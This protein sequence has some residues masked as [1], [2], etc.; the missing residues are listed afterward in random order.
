MTGVRR[1]IVV[2]TLT[3]AAS[4]AA[5]QEFRSGASS[6]RQADDRRAEPRQTDSTQRHNDVQRQTEAPRAVGPASTGAPA[7]GGTGPAVRAAASARAA[8]A[9]RH[10]GTLERSRARVAIAGARVAVGYRRP[11]GHAPSTRSGR[12]PRAAEDLHAAL[13]PARR[14][15][16]QRPPRAASA[17]TTS[18]IRAIRM[19]SRSTGRTPPT[20]SP[21]ARRNR[22]PSWCRAG[23]PTTSRTDFCACACCPAPRTCTWTARWRARW[24]TS[25]AAASACCRRAPAG[26]RLRHR[27]SRA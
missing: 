16:R 13:E 27:D 15:S 24:T 3:A 4:T 8:A 9:V 5:A 25:A 14:A 1:G 20:R 21:R 12:L 6:S 7:A 11:I 2:L 23:C 18:S 22:A 10:V 26:S 17:T 19:G